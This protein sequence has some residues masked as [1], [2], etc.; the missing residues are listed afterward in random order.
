MP[1]PL[2]THARTHTPTHPQAHQPVAALPGAGHRRA[3]GAQRGHHQARPASAR[4]T[5]V[6]SRK[7]RVLCCDATHQQAALPPAHS[8]FTHLPPH[9]TRRNQGA[10]ALPQLAHD[11][12]PARLARRQLPHSHGRDHQHGAGAGARAPPPPICAAALCTWCHLL[13]SSARRLMPPASDADSP[14]QYA[15]PGPPQLDES[16]STCRFAQR[17]AMVSNAPVV[18]EEADPAA[19]IRALRQQARA[20]RRCSSLCE[21]MKGFCPCCVCMPRAVGV[22]VFGVEG[23]HVKTGRAPRLA[24][25]EH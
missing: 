10:R 17:V 25:I 1:P 11:D 22:D 20:R 13:D 8:P 19:V 5:P 4:R 9:S 6:P 12:G 14:A 3:A 21:H 15:P 2:R 23:Q 18:N 24:L 7:A 16:I